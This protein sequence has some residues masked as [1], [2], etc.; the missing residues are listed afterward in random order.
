ME[1]TTMSNSNPGSTN[2]DSRR[3]EPGDR[4]LQQGGLS[5]SSQRAPQPR[6]DQGQGPADRMDNT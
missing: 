5:A 6:R 3:V 4:S 1:D 2:R